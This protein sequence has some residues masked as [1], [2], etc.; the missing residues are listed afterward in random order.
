MNTH[1]QLK[2]MSGKDTMLAGD[3]LSDYQR[4]VA[5]VPDAFTTTHLAEGAN[6]ARY[7]SLPAYFAA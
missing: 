5:S 1:R 7:M 2:F 3:R 6:R 4:E